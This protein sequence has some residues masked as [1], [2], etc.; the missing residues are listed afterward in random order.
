[1]EFIKSYLANWIDYLNQI[2][3]R[4]KYIDFEIIEYSDGTHRSPQ[5]INIYTINSISLEAN[6]DC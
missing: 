4:Q 2:F 6:F 3:I 5:G 1:M